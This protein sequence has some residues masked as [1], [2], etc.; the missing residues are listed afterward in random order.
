MALQ[1]LFNKVNINMKNPTCNRINFS[2]FAIFK[3]LPSISIE[4]NCNNIKT[5]DRPPMR[6]KLII[7]ADVTT[8]FSD[9]LFS[10]LNKTIDFDKPKSTIVESSLKSSV[11]LKTPNN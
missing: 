2:F 6:I 10:P 4:S 3:L 9:I 1:K 8:L 5:M 7:N 11:K